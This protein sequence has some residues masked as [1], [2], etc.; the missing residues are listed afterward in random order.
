MATSRIILDTRRAKSNGFYPIKIRVANVKEWRMYGTIYSLA[1]EEFEKLIK[2]K[3][4]SE[5][6]KPIKKKTD[7]LKKKADD[8]IEVLEPF[9]FSVFETRFL[10]KGNRSDLLF[11]LRDKAQGFADNEQYSSENLYNQAAAMLKSYLTRDVPQNTSNVISLPIRTVT[12]K[13]LN[14]LEKWALSATYDKRVKGSK[15]TVKEPKYNQT[16]LG[17][18]LIRV[19]SIFNDVISAKE[20][21][22]D[23]YPF[24]KADNKN[25]Y[26]IPQP[27]NNKRP[28]DMDKIMEFYNYQPI[29]GG[30]QVAKDFFIFSYLSSGMNMVDI[31]RLKWSDVKSNHF[32]FVRKKTE[33]KTGG[34]NRITIPLTADLLAIIER[35]GSRKINNDYIFN[36]IPAGATEKELLAATRSSIA[37]INT[38]VKKIASKLGWEEE[39]STYF[40]RHA[41]SNNLMNSEVPLAFI[42]KQL[43]HKNLKT[44]QNYLDSFTTDN[45]VKYQDNLLKKDNLN[46]K[47]S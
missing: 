5:E 26:K 22:A 17:M 10:R 13:W 6:L 25:G 12:P 3:N 16:T 24:H 14:D 15:E 11:L 9:D 41:Y 31:F 4:L 2:G 42:S 21:N 33:K 18:Y 46:L 20:L 39:P 23:A 1:K 37:G 28:L 34:T 40:A 30:E 36:V 27:I 45:A 8:I 44:T 38:A 43:G 7:A 32:S 19:R 29:T 47:T 35:H